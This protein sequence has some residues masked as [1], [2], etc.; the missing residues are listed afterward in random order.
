VK[1]ALVLS[2]GGARA[3]FQAGVVGA[4]EEAGI[5]PA[6]YSGTSAGALNAA[7]LAAGF[8]ASRLREWWTSIRDRD[9]YRMRRDLWRL[10]NPAGFLRSGNLAERF[11]RGTGW[12][13]V[14][15]AG[16]L[17]R[18]LV[19]AFGGEELDIAPG[20]QLAVSAVD[21]PHGSLVRFLSES[22]APHR[23][24]AQ[25][26]IVRFTV[27]HLLASAAIPLVFRPAEV[28]QVAHWDGGL[29]ANTPLAPALAY[30]PDVAIIVTTSSLRRPASV[31]DTLG[32]GIS[33]LLE[34]VLGY[35]LQADLARAEAVNEVCRVKGEQERKIVQFLQVHP[36]GLE[37]G[38]A[39]QFD[40]RN[41]ERLIRL[42]EERGREAVARW[43]HEGL[44]FPAS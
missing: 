30:E 39:L 14:L 3:A 22:P 9:V 40:P 38:N 19:E 37:L 16:P 43:Q 34:T 20:R 18:T 12:S 26:E 4:F 33:L 13:W 31:P 32:D 1:V 11:L 8:D 36:T 25:Q 2:G 41:A 7:A 21:L 17:R 24:D 15:D 44:R 27:D 42:G 35:S 6:V 10:P 5:A 23:A 28:D 29:V